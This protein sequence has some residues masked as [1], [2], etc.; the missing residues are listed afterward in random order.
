[1][2]L[3][4]DGLTAAFT[5]VGNIEKKYDNKLTPGYF[6][7]IKALEIKSRAD[8][9]KNIAERESLVDERNHYYE[10]RDNAIIQASKD[11]K[12]YKDMIVAILITN[13][14]AYLFIFVGLLT[15]IMY[16]RSMLGYNIFN[17][18]VIL[19]Y[20]LG[21][22]IMTFF[23]KKRVKKFSKEKKAQLVKC[24]SDFD[25]YW[26]YS[27]FVTQEAAKARWISECNRII[28]KNNKTANIAMKLQKQLN[29][30]HYYDDKFLI[31]RTSDGKFFTTSNK[32]DHWTPSFK[33]ASNWD[34]LSIAEMYAKQYAKNTKV[35]ILKAIK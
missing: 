6:E 13:I 24:M 1:M 17:W 29:I 26:S 25:Y 22:P 35:V 5:D 8:L 19:A 21:Q 9:D 28:A 18:I 14:F 3:I 11:W 12:P 30:K 23:Y 15:G 27:V 33:N 10:N 16:V 34:S 32:E 7:D 4:K 20:W 2:E 31:M